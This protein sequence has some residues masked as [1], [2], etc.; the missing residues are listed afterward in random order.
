MKMLNTE[1]VFDVGWSLNALFCSVVT[2]VHCSVMS[3]LIDQMLNKLIGNLMN[4]KKN[5]SLTYND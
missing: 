2:N 4:Y 3:I 5:I 1:K